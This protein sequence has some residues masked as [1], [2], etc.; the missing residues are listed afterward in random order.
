[1]PTRYILLNIP[2]I[3]AKYFFLFIGAVVTLKFSIIRLHIKTINL[4][5]AEDFKKAL[6]S[7]RMIKNSEGHTN[8]LSYLKRINFFVKTDVKR[9]ILLFKE[10]P[11]L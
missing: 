5:F 2:F 9:F 11:Q 4:F 1:M 10:N 7:R 6:K 8:N 3:A